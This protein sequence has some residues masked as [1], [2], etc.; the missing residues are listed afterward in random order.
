MSALGAGRSASASATSFSDFTSLTCSP[1]S[2]SL[3]E[4]FDSSGVLSATAGDYNFVDCVEDDDELHA[5]D[6]L[7]SKG[8][9]D[10]TGTILTPRGCMNIGSLFLLAFGLM[11]L[12]GGYPIV[13]TFL[14]KAE[15]KKGAYNLGGTNATGQVPSIPGLPSLIDPDTPK[16]LYLKKSADG[17]KTLKLVFSDEFNVA[18]RSFVSR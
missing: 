15:S 13:T 17:T 5:P 10:K 9:A 4:K 2:T 3:G 7:M 8:K 16:D 18:G 14:Q 1:R 12:F 11:M 6:A